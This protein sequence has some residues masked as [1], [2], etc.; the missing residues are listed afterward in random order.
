MPSY[1][2]LER[3]KEIIKFAVAARKQIVK[4]YAISVWARV[5][6]D[7]QRALVSLSCLTNLLTFL[8]A[9]LRTECV[10]LP[11]SVPTEDYLVK[12]HPRLDCRCPHSRQVRLPVVPSF[13]LTRPDFPGDG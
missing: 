12:E 10:V 7:V 4:V 6:D 5:A 2:D 13:C 11:Y 1:S 8:T 3:K 9:C